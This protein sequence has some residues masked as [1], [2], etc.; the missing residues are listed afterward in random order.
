MICG[1]VCVRD[2]NDRILHAPSRYDQT[3][4]GLRCLAWIFDHDQIVAG[5]VVSDVVGAT[6]DNILEGN[7]GRRRSNTTDRCGGDD[8]E[9]SAILR[10]TAIVAG[11]GGATAVSGI[12]SVVT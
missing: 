2:L 10:I 12:V 8:G 1:R 5:G 6:G 11:T 9:G 7:A 4:A 3:H